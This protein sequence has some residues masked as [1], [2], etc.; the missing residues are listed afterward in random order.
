M[1]NLMR[2]L[3]S[4]HKLD[5]A[6]DKE[7]LPPA[8]PDVYLFK[9]LYLHGRRSFDIPADRLDH[10]RANLKAG[11]LLLADA[12]CGKA[13]FDRA[14]R[15]FAARLFPESKLEPIPPDDPLFGAELNGS[16][17]T[18]VRLRRE[19]PDGTGAEAEFRDGRPTHLEG[20]RVGG[21][22]AVVYSRYDLGCALERHAASD[23]KGY[24]HDSALRIGAAA[25]LYA[26]KK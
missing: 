23:C 10:L 14:F 4:E 20:I 9:F 19:R 18:S 11:G 17:I 7:V 1:F 13:E 22:W 24:D 6:L 26:L 15:A 3:R 8:S 5:V 12:C 25:V 16:A 21:R 2:F